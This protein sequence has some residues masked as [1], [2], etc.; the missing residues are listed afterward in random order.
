MKKEDKDR[1]FAPPLECDARQCL[2]CIGDEPMPVSQRMFCYSRP[3]KMMDHIGKD[4]LNQFEPDAKIP[5]PHPT[6]LTDQV[7]LDGVSHFKVH[8]QS[9]H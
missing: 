8:A 5:C 3:A 6:C 4:H 1:A 2:L 7:V 9:M